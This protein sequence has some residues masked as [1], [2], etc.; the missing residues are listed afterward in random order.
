MGCGGC[1]KRKAEMLKNVAA[2]KKD[3]SIQ[4][5]VVAPVVK[6]VIP[7]VK[8]RRQLRI[9]SRA[10]RVAARNERIKQKSLLEIQKTQNGQSD[11][12][13]KFLKLPDDSGSA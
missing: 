7:V 5:S 12:S 2:A 1:V 6:P 10:K 13:L 3:I 8:T 4:P 11:S 9:E